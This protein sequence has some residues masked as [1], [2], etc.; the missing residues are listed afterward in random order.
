MELQGD[1][2]EI[3]RALDWA[4]QQNFLLAPLVIAVAASGG[5]LGQPAQADSSFPTNIEVL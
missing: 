2:S 4:R 1:A 5:Q 3:E